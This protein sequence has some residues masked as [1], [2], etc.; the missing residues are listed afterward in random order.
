MLKTNLKDTNYRAKIVQLKNIRK[1]SNAD[2]LQCVTIDFQTVITGMN[3]KE[4]DIYIYFPL[5]CAINK[6]YLSWSNSFSS[7]DMN[8]D[9][10]KKGFFDKN[11]RVRAVRLRGEPSQGYIIQIGRASCRERV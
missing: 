5:E 10:T 6:E 3:A 9:K 11:G 7:P 1:H 2:K 4:G 8:E